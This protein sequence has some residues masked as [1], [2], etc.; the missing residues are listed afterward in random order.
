VLELI[1]AQDEIVDK[2]EIK[3]MAI[4]AWVA[5]RYIKLICF[6]KSFW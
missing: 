2:S 1:Q 6:N 3:S 4:L 5:C